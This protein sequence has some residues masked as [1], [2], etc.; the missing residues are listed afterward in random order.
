MRQQQRILAL[1]TILLCIAA[2]ATESKDKPTVKVAAYR[3]PHVGITVE[4]SDTE[5]LDSLD[6]ACP[7]ADANYHTQ[8]SGLAA[9]RHF[10]R[11]FPLTELLPSLDE[12]KTPLRFEVTVRNT[13]GAVASANIQISPIRTDKSH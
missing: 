12:Q 13:R 6:I 8:L 7:E 3:S 4:A 2:Q 9:N 11:L 10:K 5:G 1:G